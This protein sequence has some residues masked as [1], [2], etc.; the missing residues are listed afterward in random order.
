[1]NDIIDG[2]L[3]PQEISLLA[4]ASGA[5]KTTLLMQILARL[6]R[7][8][9]CFGAAFCDPP[10]TVGYIAADRSWRAYAR[11]ADQ[12][13]LD[14]SQIT[15]QSLVDDPTINLGRFE[16]DPLSLLTS[17]L[18]KMPA[19]PGRPKLVIVDPLVVFLGVDTNRYHLNAG[20]LIRLNRICQANAV[21]LLGTHHATKA[22]SDYS[23]LRPQDRISGTSALQGFTSTQLFLEDPGDDGQSVLHIVCHHAPPQSI[24]LV[25]N[26][27]GLFQQVLDQN[28]EA[29]VS[30]ILAA[31]PQGKPVTRKQILAGVVGF[32]PVTLDRYLVKL[33]SAGTIQK[34]GFGSYIHPKPTLH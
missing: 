13:G 31:M 9:D 1:M 33:L 4:G 24:A 23:F 34:V 3:P 2:I 12:V 30:T 26:A 17:L 16:S 7:G 6:Q 32:S 14:L 27:H 29:I 11:L 25:R 21:T 5:G 19:D 20:K 28:P 8:E 18:G 10:P 22:R 15:V